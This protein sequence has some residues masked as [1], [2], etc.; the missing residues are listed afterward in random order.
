MTVYPDWLEGDITWRDI[1]A[2]KPCDAGRCP[3]ALAIQRVFPD[4]Q[5]TVSGRVVY[6]YPPG[7]PY[8]EA[9]YYLDFEDQKFVCKF[10][11]R[12]PVKPRHFRLGLIY[13]RP[14]QDS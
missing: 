2:G 5:V 11:E 12:E 3:Y 13:A 1:A 14:P 4:K 10:D 7:R 6:I 9:K 8:H